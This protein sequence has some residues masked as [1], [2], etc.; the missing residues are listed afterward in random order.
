MKFIYLCL[1]IFLSTNFGYSQT[2][3]TPKDSLQNLLNSHLLRDSI[4]V[5]ALIDIQNYFLIDEHKKGL[6]YIHEA[7]EISKE[8]NYGNGYGFS[9]T[10]LGAYFL[11]QGENDS[12]LVYTLKAI[13]QFES[14]NENQ[15][16]FAAFNNL[17]LIYKNS[18]QFDEAISTYKTMLE[19]LEGRPLSPSFVI[20]YFNIASIYEA[21]QNWID[22]ETWITK[23]IDTAEQLNFQMGIIEGKLGLAKLYLQKAEYQRSL[24]LATDVAKTIANTK[25]MAQTE[26]RAQ[27]IIGDV[28]YAQENPNEAINAYQK[29]IDI[30]EFINSPFYA[31]ELYL[32]VSKIL[33]EQNRFEKALEYRITYHQVKDSLFSEEKVQLIE[34]LQ[35][36]Y[37]TERVE[38]EKQTALLENLQLIEENRRG[39]NLLL[40]SF[41]LL[42]FLIIGGLLFTKQQ[43][44]KKQTDIQRIEL[45]EARKRL[46]IE[47]E[48]RN[49]ELSA[50][51]SQLNPHFLFNLLN[52][53]QELNLTGKSVLANKALNFV[54]LLMRKTLKHSQKE[55]ISLQD[56]LE[57]IELYLKA[58]EL[59]FGDRITFKIEVDEEIDAEFIGIPP[60]LIQPYV[61]NSVK[62]GL[63]HKNEPGCIQILV[64]VTDSDMLSIEIRDNGIGRE[65]ANKIKNRNKEAHSGFSVHANEKRVNN[66]AKKSNSNAKVTITDL[67]NSNAESIG[68]SVTILLP[69]TLQLS[70]TT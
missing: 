19:K 57:F 29:S 30:Y 45:Q 6:N 28:Y 25:G 18:G 41:G 68:T 21:Q 65:E 59:R 4:R 20:V 13:E 10:A 15:N 26:A 12:A 60:M 8:I 11:R 31:S 53:I 24:Q 43:Q 36:K 55:I 27:T 54:A 69:L 2:Y 51:R 58:E 66:I 3:N 33:A 52:S 56:E 16:I 64:N 63:M 38:R 23:V 47:R 62:H 42:T 67:Y 40:G 34:E 46:K 50:V 7:I 1:F 22:Y 9:L 17:A 32:K 5:N 35:T 37:E 48:K 49:A 14:T 44:L 70:E 61:E 39:R